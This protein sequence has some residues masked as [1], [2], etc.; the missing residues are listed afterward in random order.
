[1]VAPSLHPEG[2]QYRWWDPDGA[3][4]DRPPEPA[5]LPALPEAWF[6]VQRLGSEDRPALMRTPRARKRGVVAPAGIGAEVE[7]FIDQHTANRWTEAW[8]WVAESLDRD[9]SRHDRLVA[10]ADDRP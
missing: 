5:D 10:G 9:G 8:E 2:R 4:V 7:A 1:M 3:A 6:A